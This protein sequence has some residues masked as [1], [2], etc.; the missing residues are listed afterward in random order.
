MIFRRTDSRIDHDVL[1]T[2]RSTR[3]CVRSRQ[4]LTSVD[5]VLTGVS[6][7]VDREPSDSEGFVADLFVEERG[8]FE[9]DRTC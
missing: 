9:R 8:E 3:I 6:T 4:C 7:E 5:M 2:T 1:W